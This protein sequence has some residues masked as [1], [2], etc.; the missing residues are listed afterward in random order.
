MFSPFVSDSWQHLSL[1]METGGA[2]SVSPST[3]SWRI[4]AAAVSLFAPWPVLESTSQNIK[5]KSL[6]VVN[7]EK[8]SFNSSPGQDPLLQ[9]SKLSV[10]IYKFG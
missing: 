10:T 6:I 7:F 4:S 9:P 2:S 3:A 8:L 5:V 1:S